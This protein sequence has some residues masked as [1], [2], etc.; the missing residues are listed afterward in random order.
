MS[1]WWLFGHE[2]MQVEAHLLPED[3]QESWKQTRGEIRMKASEDRQRRDRP[4]ISKEFV[5]NGKLTIIAN[6]EGVRHHLRASQELVQVDAVFVI[7]LEIYFV[8][9]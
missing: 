9:G 4:T 3:G 6:L 5:K 8:E 1:S 2:N 7:V